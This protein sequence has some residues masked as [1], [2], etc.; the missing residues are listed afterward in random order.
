M[1]SEFNVIYKDLYSD[2]LCKY[3]VPALYNDESGVW[4]MY[5]SKIPELDLISSMDRAMKTI[6]RTITTFEDENKNEVKVRSD[7]KYFLIVN[8]NEM[9]LA[10]QLALRLKRRENCGRTFDLKMYVAEDVEIILNS[11]MEYVKISVNE[12]DDVKNKCKKNSDAD[13]LEI[14]GRCIVM[15]LHEKWDN[16]KTVSSDKLWQNNK[17]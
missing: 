14:T 12:E 13:M 2:Y 8:L 6:D 15:A 9:I 16:L 17:G 5:L 11:A 3:N 7:A 10:P 1:D 4:K